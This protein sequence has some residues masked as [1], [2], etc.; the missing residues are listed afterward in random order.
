MY[1]IQRQTTRPQITAHLAQTMNLLTKTVA[2]LG[3]EIAK[4]VS[5]N[6]AL[7]INEELHCPTC[8]RVIQRNGQC[9]HCTQPKST[10]SDETI[11]FISPR[12][13]FI[14]R[15]ADSDESDQEE[16]SAVVVE[17][18]ATNVLRQI[19]PELPENDRRIAA[20]LLNQL[21]D[22]GLLEVDFSE[23]SEYFHVPET[24]IKNIQKI[25]QHADP[26]GVGSSN[27]QEALLIQLASL[28][29]LMPIPRRTKEIIEYHYKDLMQKHF[30]E[31]SSSTNISIED[32]KKIAIFVGKNL[33]PFPARAYW[34]N[35]R[36]PDSFEKNVYRHPDVLINHLNNDPNKPLMVEVILP[37]RGTLQIN[38]VIKEAIKQSTGDTHEDLKN[39]LEKASLFIK[40]L[41]QRNNT[42]QRL[43]ERIV[44]YQR[45]YILEGEQQLIPITRVKI[46]RELSVHEST[47]SRAVANKS[48]RLPSGQIVPLSKFFERN[49]N[50][51]AII[52]EIVSGETKPLSDTKIVEKLAEK[53]I[54]IARRTV[55]KYRT[56]DGLLPAHLRKTL[57]KN[58]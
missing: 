58:K 12:T 28:A 24:R 44:S 23:L 50:I 34:G 56:M 25:I 20:Y 29:D 16:Q 55:A 31:I 22:D 27:A 2:E 57:Q 52:R 11:V 37:V 35:V 5:T 40:C 43:L 53:G 46:S 8:N 48:V 9:P 17:D 41:Q 38:P 54:H 26:I 51:R 7:E 1:Q 3:E 6:P 32:V 47:I 10:G 21:N 18:L 33:N 42:M 39:D 36:Q 4:E 19:A 45:K 13:D 49:L 15:S 14:S 30:R